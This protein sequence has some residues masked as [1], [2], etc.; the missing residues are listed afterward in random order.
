MSLI[1]LPGLVDPHVHL[2]D[3]GATAKEEFTTGTRAALAGGFVA[4]LD[5]PNNYDDPTVSPAALAR[6]QARAAATVCCD[7]G[8]YY[9]ATPANP[10][11]YPQVAGA[12]CGLK[13]YLD[14]TTGTLTLGDL[15]RSAPSWPPGPP[16]GPWSSTP[17]TARWRWCWG[18][19]PSAPPG[20]FRPR[21]RGG[22][23]HAD[24]R[25]EGARAA[26][27]V[28][29]RPAPP[30]SDRGRRAAPGGFG[31]MKPPLRTG[32]D[33]D[34]LWANLAVIDMIATDHAPHTRAEKAAT[35]PPFGVPGLET[36]LPLMLT[37]VAAGRLTL[38]R[39]VELMATAP[40]P[41]LRPPPRPDQHDPG[42]PR[43]RLDP[44]RHRL[45]DQMRL[46]PLRRAARPGPPARDG[47]AR[48]GRLPRR[49]DPGPAGQRAGAHAGHVLI[50][51]N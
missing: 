9:G 38:D 51:L 7:V 28:R 29:S 48:S 49:H 32:A 4:V 46:V 20:P 10:P 36:A 30:L 2:R 44:P 42:R 8:L 27:D 6:K 12:V 26:G 24:P 34:A 14:H 47:A 41:R 5:M 39:L 18:C 22:G 37:A 11:T 13:A 23:D 15:R 33:V 16:P 40:R 50:G 25:R 3:P 43:R 1:R 21:Q 35:P 45:A 19:W 31:V 17:R